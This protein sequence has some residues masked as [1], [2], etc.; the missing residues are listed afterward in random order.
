[1]R[2][3]ICRRALT[4]MLA[5]YADRKTPS[6]STRLARMAGTLLPPCPPAPLPPRTYSHPEAHRRWTKLDSLHAQQ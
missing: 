3:P 4:T 5:P 6:E 1:M 2:Q